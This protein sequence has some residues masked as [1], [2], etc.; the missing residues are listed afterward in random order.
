MNSKDRS[1]TNEGDGEGAQSKRIDLSLAQVLGSAVAAVVAAFL[2]GKLGV[3]GT[4]IGAGVMSLVATSGGPIFQHLFHRTGTQIKEATAQAKTRQAPV[5]DPAHGWKSRAGESAGATNTLKAVGPQ[6][7]VPRPAGDRGIPSSPGVPEARAAEAPGG[8]RGTDEVQLLDTDAVTRMISQA[9]PAAG[10]DATVALRAGGEHRRGLSGAGGTEPDATRPLAT[11]ATYKPRSG[12]LVGEELAGRPNEPGAGLEETQ[13]SEEFTAGTTHGTRWRGWR[14]T[15]LP[16]L[17]V[18]VVAIGGITLYEA[19]SGHS[20]SGG[21]G[22]SISEMFGSGGSSGDGQSDPGQQPDHDQPG[23]ADPSD[24]S[25]RDGQDGTRPTDAP[26]SS[27]SPDGE[28][29]GQREGGS[30]GVAPDPGQTAPGGESGADGHEGSDGGEGQFE[31]GDPDPS[32]D[33]GDSGEG[34]GDDETPQP[35]RQEGVQPQGTAPYDTNT[36]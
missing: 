25:D 23:D 22:T 1:L 29:G 6:A 7:G 21:K 20:M 16:A 9:R 26:G 33:G 30:G 5:R 18:F 3:Y 14:R 15:L 2:A 32:G 12:A 19:L 27:E 24:E 34:S 31:S 35:N 13:E 36:E 11:A 8:E 28:T 17:L 4:F 10:D